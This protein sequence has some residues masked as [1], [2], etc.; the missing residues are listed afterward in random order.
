MC[1]H[2]DAGALTIKLRR[3]NNTEFRFY[4]G[5]MKK[6]TVSIYIR[7]SK[8]SCLNFIQRH[9]E[10]TKL[11]NVQLAIVDLPTTVATSS[12]S[13]KLLITCTFVGM[14]WVRG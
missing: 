3:T 5:M 1:H 4:G 14:D 2:S 7:R 9:Y 11:H 6:T 12:N 13:A 8:N 10:N